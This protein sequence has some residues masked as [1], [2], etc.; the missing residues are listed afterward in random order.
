MMQHHRH[1]HGPTTSLLRGGPCERLLRQL[2]QLSMMLLAQ[3][4]PVSR[5][6][7]R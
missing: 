2:F 3:R 7:S 4:L 1:R 6:R 5:S